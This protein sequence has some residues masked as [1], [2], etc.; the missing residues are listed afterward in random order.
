[1]RTYNDITALVTGASSGIGKAFAEQ[2]AARGA[3]LVITARSGDALEAL[4]DSLRQRYHTRVMVIATD[5]SQPG[6][7]A[8]LYE[9][10]HRA[11]I[12]VQLLVNNAGFGKLGHFL[13]YSPAVHHEMLALNMTA[14]VDLCQF[15][16]PAMLERHDGGIINVASGAAFLPMPYATVYAASKAFV[17]HFTEGL[18]GEY[19]RHGIHIVALC[20]GGTTSNF[21]AVAYPH[22]PPGATR[23]YDSPDWVAQRALRA[24]LQDRPSVITGRMAH[25][26][27]M[28]P[29]FFSRR[30]VIA[31]SGNAWKR[32]LDR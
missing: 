13:D 26:A 27:A 30:R 19:H 14:L 24:L 4:A 9:Q 11:G 2:L 12:V 6:A 29:R 10:T 17:L 22:L 25:L 7:A 5:L 3:H 31:L 8:S 23:G 20:P 21:A 18:Y 16:L 15:Y 28:L 1:M 32:V